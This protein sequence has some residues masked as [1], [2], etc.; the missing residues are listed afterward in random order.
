MPAPLIDTLTWCERKMTARPDHPRS[1]LTGVDVL[2]MTNGMA[3]ALATIFVCNNGAKTE[4][5]P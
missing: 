1:A 5:P 4:S 2:D 3:V